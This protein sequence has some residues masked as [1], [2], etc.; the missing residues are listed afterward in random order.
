MN[1]IDEIKNKFDTFEEHGFSV[2][3]DYLCKRKIPIIG[4]NILNLSQHPG[5]GINYYKSFE[6]LKLSKSKAI[7]EWKA[8][9]RLID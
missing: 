8:M 3:I 1:L 7:P 9:K 2:Y 5:Y 4:H 6:D